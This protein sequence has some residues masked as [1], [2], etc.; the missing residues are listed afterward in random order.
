M[1]KNELE[2]NMK[3]YGDTGENLAQAL[4]IARSTLSSKMNGNYDFTQKE[5]RL[6]KERYNLTAA[7]LDSIFFDIQVS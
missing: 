2:A 6:I 7:E 5:I 1:H 3:L 4:H